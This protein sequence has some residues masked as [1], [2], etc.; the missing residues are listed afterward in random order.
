MKRNIENVSSSLVGNMSEVHEK[1]NVELFVG[2][3]SIN[4]SLTS[5]RLSWKK[6]ITE[7][8]RR[9]WKCLFRDI[10]L[11]FCV[12]DRSTLKL[13]VVMTAKLYE[14]TNPYWTCIL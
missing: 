6:K 8:F 7:R 12:A 13:V 3:E 1:N 5:S 9:Q 14:Y 10:G 2:N 4:Q 11:F